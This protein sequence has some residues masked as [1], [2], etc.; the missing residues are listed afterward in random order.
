MV[1]VEA[2]RRAPRGRATVRGRLKNILYV[3]AVLGVFWAPPPVH[4]D[5]PQT[6]PPRPSIDQ[7][8]HFFD[9]VV[10]E[11]EIDKSLEQTVVAKWQGP[12][13]IAVQG[14]ASA[15]HREFL[16]NHVALLRTLTRL[17]IDILAPGENGQNMTVVFVPR[18]GMAKVQI[19]NVKQSLIDRLAAPGGCFFLSFKKPESRIVAA[20]IVVN[21]QR[22]ER[23]INHCLLEEITQSLGLPNDSDL[24]R[25]SLFSD[26]DQLL[27][28]SR[29][30]RILIKALYD[31][32]MIP[33]MPRAEALKVV[34]R[35]I[36]E[37][38]RT[39]P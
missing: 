2:L 10:F 23:D 25:P 12:I 22:K 28:P 34:R 31:P 37:L 14:Q 3:L 1:F 17:S 36:E 21:I 19:P 18:A 13:R 5:V 16:A 15:A 38:D 27:A 29:A 9:T 35:I 32:R 30:D 33:G 26:H 24:V 6:T 7:L 4:A 11:A 39:L 8:V 20:V